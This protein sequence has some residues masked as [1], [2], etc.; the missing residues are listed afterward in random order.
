MGAGGAWRV[1]SEAPATHH[2]P[3]EDVYGEASRRWQDRFDTRR[4]ADRVAE[5]RVTTTI[6]DDDRSFIE[7]QD[8]L[9]LATVDPAGRPQCSYK[10]GAPGFVRVLDPATLAFPVY[11]GNGMFLSVGNLD[12]TAAVGLLFV[13]FARPSRLRVNGR[14]SV[15]VDDPLQETW[16]GAR[17]VVRVAVEQVFPNCPRYVHRL[18]RVEPSPY[19]PAAD[20]SAPVP[21]WKRRTW[22]HDALAADDP[23]REA[24]LLDDD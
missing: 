13:D 16:P 8:M 5:R 12:A 19:V 1:D 9:F 10:G 18:E 21:D 20:G 22:S 11:D 6:G 3:M 15:A 24:P 4:L 17:A 23:A 2:P 7:R 14:A